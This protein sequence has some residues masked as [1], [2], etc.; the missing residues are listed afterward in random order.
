MSKK[1]KS[2]FVPQNTRPA[3]I[4]SHETEYRIIKHDLIKVLAL[5]VVYFGLILGLYFTN[6]Q[7][8]FLDTW[9]SKILHF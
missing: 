6:Q 2:G 9:F 4:L 1:H 3:G 5:N 8:H 7:S